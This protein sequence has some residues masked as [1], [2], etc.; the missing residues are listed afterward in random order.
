MFNRTSQVWWNNHFYANSLSYMKFSTYVH[1]C[2]MCQCVKYW[3]IWGTALI[4]ILPKALMRFTVFYYDDKILLNV[5]SIN[6]HLYNSWKVDCIK[7]LRL[8]VDFPNKTNGFFSISVLFLSFSLLFPI[9][10]LGDDSIISYES[11]NISESRI[12]NRK[13]SEKQNKS[14]WKC[15][16]TAS[17]RRWFNE[18]S[19]Y[20]ILIHT[21]KVLNISISFK[22]ISILERRV[23]AV[24]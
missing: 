5:T 3:S 11:S 4:S 17:L 15:I 7:S 16:K 1:L 2:T 23:S 24:K 20:S 10:N 14:A 19:K 13:L 21:K 22:F 9:S 6:K 12:G 8:Q 18:N